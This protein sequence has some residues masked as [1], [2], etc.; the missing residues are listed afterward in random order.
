MPASINRIA[1]GGETSE[2]CIGAQALPCK[3]TDAL[4]P[5]T[6][7]PGLAIAAPRRGAGRCEHAVPVLE[8]RPRADIVDVDLAAICRH[9]DQA[10]GGPT[11]A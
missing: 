6:I 10:I 8:R 2:P 7:F 9:A 3:F 1:H 11:Q 4:Q 5:G